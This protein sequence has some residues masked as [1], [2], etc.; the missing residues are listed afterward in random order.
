MIF[1]KV[2]NPALYIMN[3]LS[4]KSKIIGSISILFILLVFPSHTIFLN[5]YKEN[6]LYKQQLIGLEYIKIIHK[7]IQTIQI[8]RGD[9]TR[10]LNSKSNNN[11]QNIKN[12]IKEVEEL[13]D[14]KTNSIFKYDSEKLKILNSNQNFT[15][16]ISQFAL[17]KIDI[18]T[19]DSNSREIFMEHN[20]VIKLL[21]ESILDI[22]AITLF[23]TS[24]DLRVNY[25]A[26]MIQ[27]KLLNIYEHSGQ[28][29]GISSSVLT[30][31]S[32][33]NEQ[34]KILF[35]LYTELSS[36]K[37]NLTDNK[38][39]TKLENY[40][41]IQKQTT[42][43]ADKLKKILKVID[44]DIILNQNFSY[45]VKSF[46]QKVTKAMYSQ[47]AL[48]KMFTYT[49]EITI[50]ELKENLK[51][52]RAYLIYGFLIII[53]ISL[54]IFIAFYQSI[55]ENLKKLQTASEMISKGKTDIHLTVQKKDEIGDALL[56]FN[57]M[58]NELTK[59]IS[60]LDGY[61]TAIDN[62]SIVSKTD[63][64]GVI[65][66][67]NQMFC[68]ISGYTKDELIGSPHNIIRHPDV[69]K[70]SFKNMWKTIRSKKVWKGVVKNKKKSG[71]Y[72]IVNATV[73]PILDNKGEIREY[74]A[75]RHDITE[76][77][78]NKEEIKKQRID[79]LTGLPNRNQLVEDLKTAIKPILF[80]L[81]IDDFSGFNDF[82]GKTIS[83]KTLI[84]LA[85]YLTNLDEKNR[86]KLYKL[87]ADQFILLFEEGYL[88]RDNLQYFFE[89]FIL[90]IEKNISN[91]VLKNQNRIS[92]SISGGAATYYVNEDYQKLILYSNIARKKAQKEHK[93]FLIF[94][95]SM[96]KSEDY[97][98]NIE[99]IK[100]IKEAISEDRIV[101][102]YQPIFNN[103][104]GKLKKYES[105]VRLIDKD[106]QAIS[107]FFFL[108]IA[109]RA[110]LY[111]Q[112]TRIVINKTFDKFRDLPTEFS[113]N[114]TIDDIL[115]EK[116]TNFIYQKLEGYP[117]TERVIF[118][119]T[120]SEEVADYKLINKFI[121]YVKQYSVKIAIDDF[122]S[123]YANFEHILNIDADFIKIDGSLIKNIHR[124]ENSY[125]ITEAIINFSKKL[126]RE[127]IAEFIHNEE[128][129]KIV[130]KLGA[131]YSQGFYLGVPSLGLKE[132]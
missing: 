64:K 15:K 49:Y 36:L 92:I 52:E 91:P 10:Y 98:H 85:N 124:D 88:S 116:T 96:R 122:G 43:V 83:D 128:I 111:E 108:E 72:Y 6:K 11:T 76:L 34:K 84:Y 17:I 55:T 120:E 103:K 61:K 130:K 127:T 105:L 74:V 121:K 12:N 62:S 53:L 54:Y 86:Y 101:C 87:E 5:N 37:S 126:G 63:L 4:F 104:T 42:D 109:K 7:I 78:D 50:K 82:Y 22:S 95:H 41:A 25:L 21:Q 114:L 115:S 30:E 69:P 75:V 8:H 56:A 123:G 40:P 117:N 106:G 100:R 73:L 99:W 26:D 118:E 129:Q 23:D 71:G 47:E 32:M 57:T 28:L 90:D 44:N 33:I 79:L 31:N 65:T 3:L 81:N 66:Y 59:N 2:L 13:L 60:F 39:L 77:E 80:Y 70:E 20:D 68:D 58:S 119:I 93:K 1:K 27:D 16:A 110:K 45:N 38:I 94:H 51:R 24:K 35:A 97:A 18:I 113:I 131:D 132:G 46:S 67:V 107:P 125:I 9:C 102:Y 112:I 89:E 19:K 48:Y 14:L 29:Q